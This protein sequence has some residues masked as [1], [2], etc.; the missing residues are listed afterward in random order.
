MK[1]SAR[2]RRGLFG[3]SLTVLG[4]LAGPAQADAPWEGGKRY[5]LIVGI[6]DYQ[7]ESVTDLKCA[8][9]DATL[10][11]KTLVD[12]GDFSE[13]NIFL[14][15]S[16]ARGEGDQPSLTNIVFRLEWLREVVGPADTLVF[17]FAGHGV[18]MDSETFLLTM[19]ADQ[20]SKNT[21]MVSSLRGKTLNE[22]LKQTGARNTLVLLDACRNDPTAGRGD[23]N[24][25]L[26]ANLARGLVFKPLPAAAPSLERNTATV[27]ACSEG[28][29]S[30]EWGDKNQGFFTYFLA[31]GLR[32]GAY[33][34][35]GDATL[36]GL[37]GYLRDK[38]SSMAQRETN[39]K[40]TPMLTYE[41]PGA[42]KWVLTRNLAASNP[43]E[44]IETQK[45]AAQIRSQQLAER[46]QKDAEVRKAA[47]AVLVRAQAEFDKSKTALARAE[48]GQGD[49]KKAR[50]EHEYATDM[51]N[52]AQ[53]SFDSS[54]DFVASTG[55][56]SEESKTLADAAGLAQKVATFGKQGSSPELDSLR[57]ELADLEGRLARMDTD[58]KAAV[59]RALKAE[60][61]VASLELKL[62]EKWKGRMRGKRPTRRMQEDALIKIVTSDAEAEEAVEEDIPE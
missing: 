12:E 1:I 35:K 55:R 6:D 44:Q 46:A 58:R 59:E 57:K 50:S 11:K 3:L 7:N 8:T 16:D 14:L 33:N 34:S 23:V 18:S 49:L 53:L 2:L 61:L 56:L 30:W 10:L 27:F 36:Q 39:Q 62:Q 28:E 15:S 40:Q 31:E 43:E 51:L 24:N 41:G 42:D 19:E 5:A 29:R 38:V 54:S 52:L 48:Q 22:M 37:V 9:S 60:E 26:S 25:T 13:D 4:A 20:R 21:L 32:S 47:E 17:Y 45:L